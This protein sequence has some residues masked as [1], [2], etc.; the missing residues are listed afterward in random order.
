MMV[1]SRPWPLMAHPARYLFA[2]AVLALPCAVHAQTPATWGP[3]NGSLDGSW[4]DGRHWS[5][6]PNYPNNGFPNPPGGETY[7]AII[8]AGGTYTVSI[9]SGSPNIT[10]SNLTLS[11]AGATLTVFDNFTFTT[12]NTV[13]L[14][15]GVVQLAGGLVQ[16]GT[17]TQGASGTG[18]IRFPGGNSVNILRNVA[19]AQP[20]ILDFSTGPGVWLS[21]TTNLPSGPGVTY[22]LGSGFTLIFDQTTTLGATPSSAVNFQLTG[23]SNAGLGV[24]QGHTLTLGPNATVTAGNASGSQLEQIVEGTLVN[25]GTIQFGAAAVNSSCSVTGNAFTNSGLI[26]VNTAGST[27]RTDGFGNNAFTNTGTLRTSAASTTLTT[28]RVTNTGTVSLAQGSTAFGA[29][30]SNSGGRVE[31]SGTFANGTQLTFN[32]GS[33]L[34]PGVGSS[35]GILTDNFV[36]T[37]NSGSMFAVN[38]TGNQAGTGYGQLLETGSIALNSPTLSVML[39][40]YTPAAG[41]VYTI[42]SGPYTGTFNGLPEGAVV[43][44]SPTGSAH[45]HYGNNVV[46]LVQPVPES[47][48]LLL[49]GGGAVAALGWWRRKR[50]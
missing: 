8:S 6:N 37:M 25:Q 19:L 11:D 40:N 39:G 32:S 7:S 3:Y 41:D 36:V 38:I 2:V 5:T 1:R 42:I 44:F 17:W 28:S 23:T 20:G 4:L 10:V 18:M 14:S 24:T 35:P 16:G 21:G 15:A 9:P 27:F 13:T 22:T 47:G 50:K 31:G 48:S 26:D 29:I 45:I 49:A 12:L 34:H 46:Q 33:T 43:P 30:T